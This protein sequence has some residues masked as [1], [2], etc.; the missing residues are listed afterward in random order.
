VIKK[1]F[2]ERFGIRLTLVLNSGYTIQLRGVKTFECTLGPNASYKV[3]WVKPSDRNLL[4][5]NPLE[6]AAVMLR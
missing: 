4:S 5:I 2:Q 6:I 3:T 1:F